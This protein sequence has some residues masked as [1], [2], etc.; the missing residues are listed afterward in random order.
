MCIRDRSC[1]PG[2]TL[3]VQSNM[4]WKFFAEDASE[5]PLGPPATTLHAKTLSESQK[6]NYV[7]EFEPTQNVIMRYPFM[8]IF[9][10]TQDD[11]YTWGVTNYIYTTSAYL[12]EDIYPL[13]VA[14]FE[15]YLAPVPRHSRNVL[16][17][18]YD[19][20][21]C[22]SPFHNHRIGQSIDDIHRVPCQDLAEMYPVYKV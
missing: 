13:T 19:T 9:F 10:M 7:L 18:T 14:H 11:T 6:G 22:L 21:V 8:D 20:N 15:G 17:M 1:L 2:Y 4:H 3:R 12:T 5:I 16:H